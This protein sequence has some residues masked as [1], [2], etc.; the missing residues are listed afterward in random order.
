MTSL[1]T[2]DHPAYFDR[3]AEVEAAHWWARGMWRLAGHWLDAALNRRSGLHALD[4]GCGT[5]E[6]ALRLTRRPEIVRVVGLDPSPAALAHARR[7]HGFPL[8]LGSA[9]EL[10]FDDAGFDVA[11]CFDV[12]Q[13]LPERTDRRAATEL[14]RVLRP[15]GI[16]LIRANA[17]AG[18]RVE[19]AGYRLDTLTEV[20]AS[21]GFSIR[22]AS[23]ANCLPALAHELRGRLLSGSRSGHPAGGGLRIK[24]PPPWLN[25]IM[26]GVTAIEAAIAGRL[27][28]PLPFGHSTL[29][30]A[31]REP[32]GIFPISDLFDIS[33]RSHA[34]R[35]PSDC[36]GGGPR[37]GQVGIPTQSVGTR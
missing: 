20:F 4:V 18:R 12:L 9:L 36:T 13:H 8:V 24:M 11:T 35:R 16:A 21:T 7:R 29:L 28:V 2:I 31:V 1:L 17:R 27:A 26:G 33:S 37:S 6:T 10:P 32:S 23:Y 14:Y 34:P 22:R 30:L 15:G 3:L 25:R 19:D 5:G